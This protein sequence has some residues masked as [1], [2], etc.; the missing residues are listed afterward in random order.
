MKEE[1]LDSLATLITKNNSIPLELYEQL[2][3]KRGLRNKNGTGVLV[4]LTKI[5]SVHGYKIE[6]GIKI[7]EEGRLYYRDIELSKLISVF[8]LERR[9][10]F[11]KT[12]FLT[13]FSS[14]VSRRFI[15]LITL[16]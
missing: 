8:N 14:I 6:N 12:M 13:L 3:V 1:F 7:P 10:S 2:D 16:F 9:F 5:G 15:V 4:G 11:E